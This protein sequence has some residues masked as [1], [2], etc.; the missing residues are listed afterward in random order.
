MR[1]IQNHNLAQLLM[2]L[3]FTPL[4]K[5]RKQLDS[6]EKLFEI[7]E[8]G[9]EYPFEFV[10]FKITGFHPKGLVNGPL[11]KGGELKEDLRIF[12]LKLSGQVARCVSDYDEKV[13]T[14]DELARL[15]GVSAKTINRWRKRGLI[16]RK[17]IFSDGKKLLGF[18]QSRVEKFVAENAELVE[19]AKAF[20]RLSEEEK[21]RII[22]RAIGLQERKGLSRYQLIERI[23]AE[24]GRSHETIRKLLLDHEKSKGKSRI[25][26][27][28]VGVI[29][30]V[31][32]A[33]L[34]RLYKQG[35][36][37]KDLMERFDRSK[38]SIYRIINQ[39]R[40]K[41]LLA[42]KIEFVTSDE[43]FEEGAEERIIGRPVSSSEPALVE[44]SEPFEMVGE[45]LLPKYL[46]TLRETPGL[47]RE[48]EIELFRRYNYL[49]Y[50]ACAGIAG[51]KSNRV[52]GT[53]LTKIENYLAEAEVIKNMIIEANL[54][55][56]VSIA[57]K[58]CRRRSDFLDLVSKGN[59]ALVK[60]V[61][62][63]D[64]KR[65]HRFTTRVS[66][67]IAKYYAQKKPRRSVKLDEATAAHLADIQ[68]ELRD[69]T[70]ADVAAI[71]R[72]HRS[73]AQVIKDNLNETEQYVI[74]NRFGPIG[75]PI[76]RETKTLKQIGDELDLTR[77]RVRQ[78]ELVALQKLRQCLSIEDFKLLTG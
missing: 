22:K 64:Y 15:Y 68:R 39:R 40:V 3:R 72:E 35:W 76:R 2:Q 9:R 60:A 24:V 7:I 5:R 27:K 20:R 61:E 70:V 23:A 10:C 78:I 44:S 56:V 69:L 54:R 42:K 58:H 14:V 38:S 33:E 16:A 45:F 34:Y 46:Q 71:E 12:I 19:G 75:S 37:V 17:F 28:R 4:K 18:T 51:L 62:E 26:G 57:S 74:L 29:E 43:F 65:G 11:I 8:E 13:Y 48:R 21:R 55:L 67:E 36:S 52:S 49:K 59:F 50:L 63:F 25:F 30:P 66:W 6:A 77:E 32:A 73:L 41:A 47:T 53:L 1:K 31:Q